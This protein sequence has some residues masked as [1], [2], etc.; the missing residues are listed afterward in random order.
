[1]IIDYAVIVDGKI[2]TLIEFDGYHHYTSAKT[3]LRDTL[4][5][6]YCTVNDIKL[7]RV[8]YFIQ[9]NDETIQFLFGVSLEHKT[10][11]KSGF[12]SL[13]QSC[14]LPINFN[15][16]GLILYNDLLLSLS[17]SN[18][19]TT[20]DEIDKSYEFQIN[21]FRQHNALKELLTGISDSEVL[22][23]LVA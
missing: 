17:K 12:W 21:T 9:L 13:E 3:Q 18:C 14:V 8:P 2:D 4:L 7:V 1:M 19:L 11:Y 15:R 23:L 6:E 5:S 16:I 20:L 10:D 22:K